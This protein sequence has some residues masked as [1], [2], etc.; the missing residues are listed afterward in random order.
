MTVSEQVTDKS[1]NIHTVIKEHYE[2]LQ[3]EMTDGRGRL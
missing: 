1:V 3:R 2:L